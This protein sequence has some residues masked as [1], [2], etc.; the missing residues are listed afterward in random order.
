[1]HDDRNRATDEGITTED[2]GARYAAS[3]RVG[4][5]PRTPWY[6]TA[7]AEE[8][9]RTRGRWLMIAGIAMGLLTFVLATVWWQGFDN[10]MPIGFLL[11]LYAI[12]FGAVAIGGIELISRPNRYASALCLHRINQLDRQVEGL[13]GLL[14]EELKQQYYLGVADQAKA[15]TQM[16][17]GTDNSRPERYRTGEVLNF[18][19]RN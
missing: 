7:G 5:P 11:P 6:E 1:M 19:G 17:T 3:A 18:R 16:M 14:S 2:L 10:D 9:V 12:A 8:H 13:V 4:R 15:Q